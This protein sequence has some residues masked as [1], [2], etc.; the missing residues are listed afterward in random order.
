MSQSPDRSWYTKKRFNLP[1]LM[2]WAVILILSILP[3]ALE[4]WLPNLWLK[5]GGRQA[6]I[7]N[8]DLNLFTGTLSLKGLRLSGPQDQR[9]SLKLLQVDIAPLA[10]LKGQVVIESVAIHG[11]RLAIE[12]QK[13]LRIAGI[14]LPAAAPADEASEPVPAESPQELPDLAIHKLLLSDLKLTFT[15]RFATTETQ[16]VELSLSDLHTRARERAV[17]LQGLFELNGQTV[18]VDMQALPFAQQPRAEGRLQVKALN[19]APFAAYAGEAL[20]QLQGQLHIDTHW[21]LALQDTA[22]Q[23]DQSGRLS[24]QQ[25][26]LRLPPPQAGLEALSVAANLVLDQQL[27]FNLKGSSIDLQQEGQLDI[28][29]LAINSSPFAA[30][31]EALLWQGSLQW[32]Q[33]QPLVHGQ[34]QLQGLHSAVSERA[35]PLLAWSDLQLE[36]VLFDGQQASIALLR[37][38]QLE[39]AALQTEAAMLAWEQL[40]LQQLQWQ[41]QEAIGLTVQQIDIHQPQLQVQLDPQGQPQGLADLLATLPTTAEPNDSATPQPEPDTAE[42][43]QPAPG[44]HV[45]AIQVHGPA[46][47]SF[48][49]HSVTPVFNSEWMIDSIHVDNV[50]AETP[51]PIRARLQQGEKSTITLESELLLLNPAENTQAQ[52]NIERLSLPPISSYS[53]KASGYGVETGQLDAE[54]ALTLQQRE[55]ESELILGLDYLSLIKLNDDNAEKMNSAI[56]MPLNLALSTLEDKNRH[57]HLQVPIS[58]NIDAPDFDLS[59]VIRSAMGGAM[60]SA[61]ISYLKHAIQPYGTLISVFSWLGKQ[62]TNIRLHPVEF[63]AGSSAIDAAQD[64]PMD[65]IAALLEERPGLT[66]KVCGFSTE[67]DQQLIR[68]LMRQE[69]QEKQEKLAEAALKDGKQHSPVDYVEDQKLTTQRA[70]QLADLRSQATRTAMQTRGVDSER[71]IECLS[72]VDADEDALARVEILL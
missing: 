25:L 56:G 5:A 3:S 66:L 42:P 15:D 37:V 65:K 47:L 9:S 64:E 71:L 44:F 57:I 59:Q 69:H 35:D 48:T 2:L 26:A 28:S 51:V 20:E 12:Q 13:Q 4:V 50:Q 63:A 39:A 18:Q 29:Q 40:Q 54:I 55:I 19:L 61:S 38:D 68:Q 31:L 14:L 62:A 10:L 33:E 17:P 43:P 67:A 27:S 11:L 41:P 7:E 36:E 52:I 72:A 34:L 8:L 60:K 46:P 23:I 21:S 30:G 70:L 16:I 1:L 58:G 6:H 22:L 32:Q 24:L 53:A 45:A 49:D